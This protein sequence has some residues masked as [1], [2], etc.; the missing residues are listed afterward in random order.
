[1]GKNGKNIDLAHTLKSIIR[2]KE[3]EFTGIKGIQGIEILN[4][5]NLHPVYPFNTCDFFLI[6]FLYEDHRPRFRHVDTTSK[7]EQFGLLAGDERRNTLA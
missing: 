7:A 5:L 4:L 6:L 3:R 1:M 2:D